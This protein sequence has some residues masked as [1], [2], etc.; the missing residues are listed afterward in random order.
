MCFQTILDELASEDTQLYSRIAV[1]MNK[2]DNIY[3]AKWFNGF[4]LKAVSFEDFE[5]C[6]IFDWPEEEAEELPP[7]DR[8][9]RELEP[10]AEGESPSSKF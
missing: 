1:R 9:K 2:P 5:K 7:G 8:R 6:G 4:S 10:P 3:A